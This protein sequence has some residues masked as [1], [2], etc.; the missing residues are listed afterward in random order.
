[1]KSVLLPC[2]RLKVKDLL[3]QNPAF[4]SRS[5]QSLSK[6]IFTKTVTVETNKRDR[7]GRVPGKVLIDVNKEQIRRGIAWYGMVIF[8]VRLLPT[9]FPTQILRKM[10]ERNSGDCG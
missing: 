9:E 7:Y 6:L 10:P 3:L 5:R 4:G 2:S 8:V 1:M